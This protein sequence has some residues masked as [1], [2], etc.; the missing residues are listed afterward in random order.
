MSKIFNKLTLLFVQLTVESEIKALCYSAKSVSYNML[1][2]CLTNIRQF[3]YIQTMTQGSYSLILTTTILLER[4]AKKGRH[5]KGQ[6]I[7]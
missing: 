5:M 6:E 1:I 3:I 4:M 2:N 7:L